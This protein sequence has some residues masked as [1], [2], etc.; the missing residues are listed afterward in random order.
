MSNRLSE[1][2]IALSILIFHVNRKH[3]FV[4]FPSGTK[5]GLPM[6]SWDRADIRLSHASAASIVSSP[7]SQILMFLESMLKKNARTI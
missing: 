3:A 1:I 4:V 5:T 6:P 7:P 2:L